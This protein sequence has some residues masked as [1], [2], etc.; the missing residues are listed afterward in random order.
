LGN[1]IKRKR[2]EKRI[3]SFYSPSF[4]FLSIYARAHT[5]YNDHAH[6]DGYGDDGHNAHVHYDDMIDNVDNN[7][8]HNNTD[9]DGDHDGGDHSGYSK[10]IYFLDSFSVPFT[11]NL[12][13]IICCY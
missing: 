7:V 11:Y 1:Q 13:A 2:K 6:Y 3:E 8:D 5:H 9:D 10:D 4:F 12:I